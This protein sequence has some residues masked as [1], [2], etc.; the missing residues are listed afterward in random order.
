MFIAVYH[1]INNTNL[2][3]SEVEGLNYSLSLQYIISP[4]ESDWTSGYPRFDVHVV[5]LFSASLVS[6]SSCIVSYTGRGHCWYLHCQSEGAWFKVRSLSHQLRQRRWLG[7]SDRSSPGL[8]K[9]TSN[10]PSSRSHT[11]QSRC[12]YYKPHPFSCSPP[13]P[14]FVA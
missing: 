1:D 14:S 11:S 13:L 7:A 8:Q 9:S 2:Y 10:L 5:R 6:L 12:L 4:P 3:L